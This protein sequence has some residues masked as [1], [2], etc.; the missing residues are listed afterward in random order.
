MDQRPAW[1]RTLYVC[2]SL[3]VATFLSSAVHA[4][5]GPIAQWKF[6]EGSGATTTADS[7]GTGHTGT[8]ANSP[9]WLSGRIGNAL[10]FN[11]GTTVVNAVGGGCIN[12]LCATGLT[13][14]AWINVTAFPASGNNR[15]IDKD[16]AVNGSFFGV[17]S[18][19]KLEFWSDNY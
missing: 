1:A 15:I 16:N 13:V 6:D 3:A 17:N 8:L 5:S 10:S 4:Q 14:S 18:S 11:G 19:S 2:L 12:N 9:A 7:S